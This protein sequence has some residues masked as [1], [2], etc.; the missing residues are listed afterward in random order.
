MAWT[1]FICSEQIANTASCEN[2]DEHSSSTR[3][4]EFLDY[5]EPSRFSKRIRSRE[6]LIPPKT[7]SPTKSQ[8]LG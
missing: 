6:F 8:A 1:E 7:Y 4:G 2:D 5:W 3:F